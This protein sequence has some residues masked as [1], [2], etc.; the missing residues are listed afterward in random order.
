[1]MKRLLFLLLVLAFSLFAMSE[2]KKVALLQ[3]LNGDNTVKVEGIEMNM[4]RGELRK[5]I[6]NQPGCQAFTRTDIDQLMKEYG[7]QNS[8]MVSDAQRKRLGEMSGAD[9]L[10]VSTLTKSNTQFYLEAYL[11]DVSTGEISNPAS[12][13]G[14]LK[15][16]SYAN[17]FQLCQELARELIGNVGTR[18]EQNNETDSVKGEIIYSDGSRYSGEKL[19]GLPHGQG[20]MSFSSN[21]EKDRV[22][23][24][25]SWKNGKKHGQGTMIGKDGLKYVGNWENDKKHGQGS[26]IDKNGD[27]KYVGNFENGIMQGQ[28]TWFFENGNKFVGNY[29]NGKPNGQGTLFGNNGDKYVGNFENGKFQGQGTY[30]WKNGDK[31]I[32]NFE[33]NV[34]HGQGTI[35]YTDGTY[36]SGTYNRGKREDKWIIRD[37][38]GT[39]LRTEIYHEGNLLRTE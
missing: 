12:Q 28:G 29:E 27:I 3:T 22:S 21:D 7:F 10:C 15:D 19:N 34:Y 35:Y 5:A 11:I 33:N 26:I 38:N 8:G 13:Y 36:E 18:H 4:V 30:I 1:M 39:T 32:G 24:E 14:M 31:Y 25:G 23:Y 20:T 16:G 17:L 2:N 6:S 9:Y 37:S